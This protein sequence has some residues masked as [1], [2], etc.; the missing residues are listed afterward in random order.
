MSKQFLK[1]FFK[2]IAIAIP[3]LIT[4]FYRNCW[5][6]SRSIVLKIERKC[7]T[8][9]W[10]NTDKILEGCTV[11]YNFSNALITE[12]TSEEISKEIIT[13][14]TTVISKRITEGDYQRN[15]RIPKE[16][17]KIITMGVTE[18]ILIG[19]VDRIPKEIAK[20]ISNIIVKRTIIIKN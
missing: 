7:W 5:R 10:K 18:W 1:W 8:D 6:N 15:C 19:I 3:K 16:V 12:E 20:G 9:S 13:E 17:S 14:I 11:R 4:E 2:I